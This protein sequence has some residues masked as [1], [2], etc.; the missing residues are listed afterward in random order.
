[1]PCPARIIHREPLTLSPGARLGPYE[2]LTALGAGGM[3]EV[4]RA[5]DPKLNRDVAIKVLPESFAN[6]PERV[7]RFQREAQVLASLN[8]PNIGGIYGLEEAAGVRALVLE[9]VEGPTLADRIAQGSIPLD[10]ALPIARQIAEA[11][12]AAHEHGIIHRDLKPS[13]IKVRSDAAVKV[14][15]FGLAKAMDPAGATAASNS[16]SPTITTPAHLRQGYG[17]QAMTGD[18]VILGTAAY[19]SPEQ[20]R[21]KTVDR[22]ADIW[23]FGAVFYEMLTGKRAFGGDGVQDTLAAIMRDEPDWARLP[24][25]L[26]PALAT[27]IRRCL[28]KDPRQRIHDIADVRLALEGAF[29]TA[30]SLGTA[31][32]SSPR[33]R[34]ALMAALAVA[35][36]LTA[37]VLAVPALRHLGETPPPAPSEMR[38]DIVM[39][40]TDDPT[41]RAGSRS[42]SF[43]LSPDGRQ[44]VFVASGVGGPSRL[45]LRSLA[46]TTAQPLAGSEGAIHPFW[47]PSSR[48][49]GFFA[50]G[51]LKRLDLD[52]GA[53]QTLAP[54]ENGFGGT[55]NTD[56][57]I[58]FAPSGN[59]GLMRVS[60]T[61]GATTSVTTPGPQQRGHLLPRFLP[62]GHRFLFS[63]DGPPDT[64]GIYLGA[65]DGSAPTRLVASDTV[66]AG[67]YLPSGWMLWVRAGT[68]VAQR[69]DV[70][71]ATLAGEPVTVAD[72][73][74]GVSVAATGLVAYGNLAASQRQLTWVDRSGTARATVGNPDGSLSNPRLSSDGRVVV[75]RTVQ[76]NTDLWLLDRTRTIRFTFDAAAD[77]FPIWSPDGTRLVFRSNRTRLGD[78]YQKLT[79]GTGVEERFLASD[80]L[81]APMSWSADGRFLLYLSIDPK[82]VGD[83]WVVP[84]VGDR[85]PS[86]FLKTPF[87]VAYGSFSPDSRWVA[88]Q[89]NESGRSEIYVRP[90]VPPGAAGKGAGVAAG[91]WQVSVA[92]GIHPAWR[93]D[94]KELY[95]INPAGAMMAA[96]ITVTGLNFDPGAPELLFPTRIASGGVDDA[97]G[98]QGRQYDVA[99]DGRFLINTLLDSPAAPITLLMNW[100]PEATK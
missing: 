20:A 66:D 51:A 6:D 29:E 16:M 7:V 19:M 100:T 13:N 85:T 30:I 73:V 78:L 52:G 45:W 79:S 57:V 28:H 60:A 58:V 37:I 9:L 55:W 82:T 99:P 11:L 77:R 42:S 47:A 53:P 49:V 89:S 70:A 74:A 43:A 8:H 17:G 95:F 63:A 44:I 76:G 97:L 62:G 86:V 24:A 65:L 69:L 81:K 3:G 83:L 96:P 88:Y 59:A 18:G 90:F 39:P 33:R 21:G 36:V 61:G 31:A 94:G 40:V 12:E 14:L 5:R 48:S 1:M 22:R 26:S 80:Q 84:M 91:Q 98:R 56:G 87:R 54:A 10:E 23:A 41:S 46:T 25:T 38:L 93:P 64:A 50:G 68:L 4:Y 27:F 67:A 75:E 72:G 2:I 35:A 15:D 34:L 32:P 71:Q 92:G